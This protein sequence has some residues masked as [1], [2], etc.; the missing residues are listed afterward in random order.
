MGTPAADNPGSGNRP[1][2]AP[3]RQLRLV[4]ITLLLVALG[5]LL[6]NLASVLL[7]LF[8][9]VVIG[10]ILR[11]A[12]SPLRRWTPLPEPVAVL[13]AVLILITVLG[14]SGWL[15]GSQI[16]GELAKLWSRLPDAW[17][18]LEARLGDSRLG[19]R[20]LQMLHETSL[21][22]SSDVASRLTTFA[23]ALT[24]AATNLLIVF[25]AGIYLALKPAK[26]RD[27]LVMLF[28]KG[29]A[30]QVRSVFDNSGRALRLWL[31]GQLVSMVTVGVLTGV[32]LA[33]AGVPSAAGLGLLAGLAE[34]VPLVGPLL[35]AVPG[36]ILA[37]SVG[38]DTMAWALVVYLAVQQLE[39]NLI[40]PLVE[41][42][43]V[44]IPP[45]MTLFGVLALGVLFGPLGVVLATPLVVV[46]YVAVKQVYVRDTLGHETEIPGEKRDA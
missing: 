32:G 2:D 27:G 5:F 45:A 3:S 46:I 24:N 30:D 16:S 44:S 18:R 23:S 37:A 4:I 13:A 31:L 10:V 12:S 21:P 26:Y 34:F 25:F 17:Q 39:S 7:L 6:L 42:R 15:F 11:A 9:A 14:V 1:G 19:D 28:P 29:R 38:G 43:A 35:S 40:T 41:K 20:L 33:L 8:G 36:L 22:G